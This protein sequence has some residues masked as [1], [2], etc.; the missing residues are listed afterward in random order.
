MNVFSKA[1]LAGAVAL[2]SSWAMS[3]QAQTVSI[4]TLPPGSINN[5]QTQAIAKVVQEKAGIQMRVI[6]FNSPA[7]SMGAVQAGEA[8]FTFMSNDEVGIAVRG[9]D[10]HAGK[11]LDKLELA[12]TVFPFKVGVLVRDDSDIKTVA[13]LKGKRFPTGWQ[14]FPQGIALSNAILATAGL[15]LEDT[16]GVP[17]VNLLRAADDFKAGRL[18]ATVF[19]VGAPKMAEIDASVKIRFL[20]LDDSEQAKTAMAAIRPEYTVA[21]QKPLPHLNGVIGDTNL[22][23]YAMT[24]AASSDVDEETVY[25][26]VKAIH[27]NKEGLVAAHPSFNAMNPDNISVLQTDVKYHPGAIR[28]YKEIGIWK[29]E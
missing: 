16:D 28:Y 2:A 20:S 7:A 15:S 11:P 8:G 9:K 23:Q 3:A 29:G 22:M 25:K 1:A 14:G 12:A 10:E 17:T 4:S 26:V 21:P 19:A 6:T 13:D 5:V 27:E 18:D 24:V